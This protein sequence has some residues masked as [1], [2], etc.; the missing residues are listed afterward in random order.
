YSSTGNATCNSSNGTGVSANCTFYDVTQGDIV[1]DCNGPNC[2]FGGGAVGVLSTSN[3]AF[4]PAYGTNSGGDFA[5]GIG[6]T[7]IADIVS[8][9]PA[10]AAPN[11][12]MSASPTSV[13]ILQGSSGSSTI[14]ITP[15]NGFS[16]NV[17]LS[18]SGLPS[19]VTASFNPATT[20]STST[21][22]LTV[23]GTAAVGTTSVTITRT[24]GGLT[25]QTQLTLAINPAPSFTL[26]ASPSLLSLAHVT[27]TTSFLS[28]TPLN[29]FS[30]NVSLSASGLPGGVTASFNP[31]TTTSTSTLTL[32]VSGTAAVGT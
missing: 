4:R 8:K 16:D 25:Q 22:T 32:T 10:I 7:N 26:S 14:S 19:G 11:F 29:G 24:S 9:G 28:I 31:A 17:N 12:T 23:S 3:T 13:T 27:S 20:T 21:L 6:T 1:V 18:A 5:P 15:L 30:D 2:Y